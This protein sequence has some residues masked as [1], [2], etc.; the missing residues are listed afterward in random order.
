MLFFLILFVVLVFFLMFVILVVNIFNFGSSFFS[1]VSCFL[2]LELFKENV[3]F[4]FII[5]VVLVNYFIDFL[6][7]LLYLLYLLIVVFVLVKVCGSFL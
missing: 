7:C 4:E 5:I 2:V 6:S 1:L 3:V